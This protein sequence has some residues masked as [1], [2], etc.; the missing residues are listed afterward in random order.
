M[1]GSAKTFRSPGDAMDAG[2]GLVPEER[3]ADALFM[4]RSVSENAALIVF[5]KLL[6]MGFISSRKQAELVESYKK[7]L[8]I[9][10]RS[11]DQLVSQLS[12]GN[13]QKVVLARWL[14]RN[15]KVIIL[16]EPTRG[17]DVG[18]REE[19]YEIIDNLAKEGMAILV[20]SSDMNEVLGLADRV[21]VMRE[22][23]ISGQM[24]IAEATQERIL[25][26]AMPEFEVTK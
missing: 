19:I 5:K 12:G 17:V 7:K 16:D 2:I 26:L 13:Q 20:I 11:I 3:R 1:D 21:I 24:D 8:K 14:A 15:L 10:T 4:E 23:T 9:R 22:G 18:A 25:E 6:K